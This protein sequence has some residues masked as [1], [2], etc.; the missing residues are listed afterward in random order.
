[1]TNNIYIAKPGK[2]KGRVDVIGSKSI[3]Q[4]VFLAAALASGRSEIHN[5]SFCD[6]SIAVLNIIQK[7]GADVRKE[8][9]TV[10]VNG[11]NNYNTKRYDDISLDCLESG[12]TLRSILPILAV[13][14]SNFI[15]SGKDTL[16][17]RHIGNEYQLLNDYIKYNT[18][19]HTYSIHKK[20]DLS[21]IE[22][23]NPDSSQ[24]ISGLLISLPLLNHD[25]TITIINPKS[26]PY[27]DLTVNILAKFGIQIT[28]NNTVYNISGKQEYIPKYIDI[29]GDMSGA[30]FFGVGAAISGILV[31]N[32]LKKNSKQGDKNIF[33]ILSSAGARVDITDNI[34]TISS[35]KLKSFKYDATNTPDL[36]PPLVALA[37][38]CDGISE[39]KGIGRL[40]QKESNRKET[41]MSEFTKLGA[42]IWCEGDSM[43]VKDS[44]LKAGIVDS[45]NDHRIAMALSV[46]ALNA[47]GDVIINQADCVNKSYPG[48][49]NILESVKR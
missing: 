37:I 46:A 48:F 24:M 32:N 47:E 5:P 8:G 42:T 29:E 31:L 30:A 7:L 9:N 11:I 38:N 6:D 18:T 45:H 16:I 43:F 33:D 12:F 2:I 41:L 21:S 35:S 17:R 27:I 1:M 23:I 25:S 20:L 10:Y 15:V 19:E 40:S 28:G 36:F 44:V 13:N 14:G 22:L 3:T 26:K 34:F 39:I 49:Y 4:R